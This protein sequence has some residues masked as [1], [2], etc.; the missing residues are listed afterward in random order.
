[1]SL[2]TGVMD[3]SLDHGYAEAARRRGEYGTSRIPPTAR[4]RLVLALGLA[5]IA[6]VVTVG[7]AQSHVA[8]PTLAKER[9][10]LISRVGAENAT[11]DRLQ[12]EIQQLRT[13]VDKAQF[14]AL[15]S[16]GE[17]ARLQRLGVLAGT[18]AA[19]GSG[20]KLTIDDAPAADGAE[21][22][23]DPRD[24]SG[25]GDSGRVRDRDLQLIVNGLWGAGAEAISINGQ[26]LTA[27]SAIRAAGDAV[28]VDNRPLVPPYTVLA[29]G[30]GQ[31]LGT[32]FRDSVSGRYL[33][34]LQENYG[35]RA[36]ISVRGDIGVSAAT[37]V[38][39]RYA[40]P[41]GALTGG[42]TQ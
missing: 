16:S 7:A 18:V 17:D 33:K 4:G 5:F 40:S 30:G 9:Q 39:L 20:V 25:F 10:E 11:T 2:L 36:S 29:I 1:M 15:R 19:T 12:Q 34:L 6:V 23:T 38:T 28:L 8:A 13:K 41:V 42:A 14:Q 31:Q 26:R 27:L 37:V 24:S 32:D 3:N 22:G 21:G 35:I